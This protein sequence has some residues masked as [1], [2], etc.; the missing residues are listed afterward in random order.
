MTTSPIFSHFGETLSGVSCI[1]AFKHQERFIE[2]SN[3]K[4]DDSQRTWLSLIL[5]NRWLSVRM[6]LC[7]NLIVLFAAIF[8]VIYKDTFQDKPGFVGL[9]IMYAFTSTD[10]LKWLVRNSCEM[11]TSVVSVERIGEYCQLPTE[12]DW[13]RAVNQDPQ[14]PDNWPEKGAIRFEDYSVRYRDGLDPVLRNITLDVKA[15]EKIGIVGRTGAGKSSLTLAL[16]RILEAAEGRILIDGIEISRLGL[17]ELRSKLSIIP[18]DPILFSGTIRSN[19]DPLSLKSD[20]ELWRALEHCHLKS[21]VSGL[22]LGLDAPV[23]ENGTNLS[24]GERQLIC[25]GRALLRETRI[26]VLDE[27]TAAVDLAT[28]GLVQATISEH[29]G[30]CTLLTIA[31]RLHTVRHSDRILALDQGAI[32]EFD[33]PDALLANTNSLFHSLAKDAGIA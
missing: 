6:E 29:L 3:R 23:A 26:L 8:A 19:L 12:R 10:Y 32:A 31:H 2:E 13:D 30:H 17:H 22:G 33:T 18:Q 5:T 14:L 9:I 7:G 28:D 15:G 20:N 1:R 24:V 11:E 16:F 27:A 25:L 21:T 4:V